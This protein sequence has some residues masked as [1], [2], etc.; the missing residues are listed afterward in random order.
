MLKINSIQSVSLDFIRLFAAQ[1]VVLG[2]TLSFF[3]IRDDMPYIQNSGVVIFFVLSGLIISYTVFFKS[4]INY[5]FK[6]FFIERFARIYTGLLPSLLFIALIDYVIRTQH[7]ESYIY[8]DAYNIKTFIGNIL[9]LQDY[10]YIGHYFVSYIPD[11]LQITSFGSGRP[12]WTLAI[13]WWL[14]MCFGIFCRL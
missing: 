9:M 7:P 1:L 11:S 13:E 5:S 8:G 10:Q 6:Q 12:L 3:H 2:H 4:E 14:Y